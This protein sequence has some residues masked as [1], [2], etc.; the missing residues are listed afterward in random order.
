ERALKDKRNPDR[1]AALAEYDKA[2]D[3]Y[4]AQATWRADA[5]AALR[6]QLTAYIEGIRGTLGLRS[7]D[8]LNREQALYMATCNAV[9]RD[10]SLNF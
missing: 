4:E 5:D 3:E 7:Q 9:H 8:R 2:L 10:I 6:P 1:V